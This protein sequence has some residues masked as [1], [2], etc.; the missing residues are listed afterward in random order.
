[1]HGRVEPACQQQ[2]G[3]KEKPFRGI[4]DVSQ[5]LCGLAKPPLSLQGL[6]STFQVCQAR[7]S[8][9]PAKEFAV[10]R[11]VDLRLSASP[12]AFLNVPVPQRFPDL[13]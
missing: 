2:A 8:Q 9:E 3:P 4:P 11:F 7:A 12:R 13:F 5:T 6:P 10:A 1:M